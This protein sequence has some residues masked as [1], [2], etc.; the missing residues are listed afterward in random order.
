VSERKSKLLL[1]PSTQR[2]FCTYT[3]RLESASECSLAHARDP[4]R[5]VQLKMCTAR[6]LEHMQARRVLTSIAQI[7]HLSRGR[8]CRVASLWSVL[9]FHFL[10]L[11]IT[12]MHTRMGESIGAT[13]SHTWKGASRFLYAPTA[14]LHIRSRNSK[15]A[16]DWAPI[17]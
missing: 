8:I 12:S 6:S 13:V 11:L 4:I 17:A 3:L 16:S 9:V 10:V 5:C 15:G 7:F 2:R 1:I 14:V